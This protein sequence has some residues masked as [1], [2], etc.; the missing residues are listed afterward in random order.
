V[1]LAW[2]REGYARWLVPETWI[3]RDAK[4]AVYARVRRDPDG[5]R[6]HVMHE[7]RAIQSQP[8]P[9]KEACA[10]AQK[11]VESNPEPKSLN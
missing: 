9:F 6:A 3:L 10:R 4:F 8:L 2:T 1:A 5:W 7:G 11:R